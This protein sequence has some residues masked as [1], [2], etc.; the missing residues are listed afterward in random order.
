MVA[1][2]NEQRQVVI[3]YDLARDLL[4][5]KIRGLRQ[6]IERILEKWGQQDIEALQTA[7]RKGTLPEA[8]TDAIIL[9]NLSEKLR[10][11]EELLTTL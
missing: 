2:T 9:G 10:E 4:E 6:E 5:S 1:D 7:T 11:Y 8:E 3:P